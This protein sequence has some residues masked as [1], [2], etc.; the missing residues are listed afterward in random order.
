MVATGIQ[1]HPRT[2]LT[3][4][5]EWINLKSFQPSKTA[6]FGERIPQKPGQ[7]MEDYLLFAIDT[8]EKLGVRKPLPCAATIGPSATHGTS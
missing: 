5:I 2:R 6:G 8:M 1:E 4:N 3:S 7:S